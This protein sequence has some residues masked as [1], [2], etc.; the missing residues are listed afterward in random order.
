M[1]SD[2]RRLRSSF[3]RSERMPIV[4]LSKSMRSA[5]FGAWIGVAAWATIVI[6]CGPRWIRAPWDRVGVCVCREFMQDS[7]GQTCQSRRS[8]NVKPCYAET[9]DLATLLPHRLQNHPLRPL[10]VPFAVE[11]SLPRSEV[12]MA[13]R[14]RHDHLVADRDRAQMRRGVVLAGAAVMPIAFRIPRRHRLL[15]PVEN[16]F[17]EIRLVIIHEYRRRDVHRRHEHHAFR[18]SRRGSTSFD[19]VGDVDDLLAP[20]RVEGEVIGVCLHGRWLASGR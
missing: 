3:P 10:S 4:T 8:R 6:A 17:P 13:A 19:G 16:V 2:E 1:M 15:E 9:W 11:D 12:E 7:A 14:H 18:D 20:L 5:A